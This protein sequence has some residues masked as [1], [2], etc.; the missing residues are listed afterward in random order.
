MKKIITFLSFALILSPAISAN[1][2][3]LDPLMNGLSYSTDVMTWT[4]TFADHTSLG[5]AWCSGRDN[6][7]DG[8]HDGDTN[9]IS[10]VGLNCWCKMIQPYESL[11]WVFALD[12][13]DMGGDLTDCLKHCPEK[14]AQNVT[15]DQPT[16]EYLYATDY[17]F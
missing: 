12:V 10:S 13:E 7:H 8:D 17:G 9:P 15:I 4:V 5:L 14:C 1:K 2:M 16:R 11:I 6:P 3:P